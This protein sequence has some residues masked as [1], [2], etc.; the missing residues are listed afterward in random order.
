MDLNGVKGRPY[1]K[2]IRTLRR[3][4]PVFVG[5]KYLIPGLT[6]L[7]LFVHLLAVAQV[8][9][10]ATSRP[11]P[12]SSIHKKV[13]STVALALVPAGIV[14]PS[15]LPAEAPLQP[16]A[17]ILTEV[18]DTKLNVRFDYKK[19]HLLGTAILTLRSHFYPQSELVL[20]A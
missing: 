14:V 19:Q 2:L 20:D 17:T 8:P 15:W 6:T 18:I 9:G 10:R 13:V 11:T 12:K 1:L 5:M 7:L 3:F 16:A 4:P